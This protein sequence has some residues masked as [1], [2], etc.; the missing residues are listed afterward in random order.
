MTPDGTVSE[1]PKLILLV[2]DDPLSLKL[3][4]DVLQA[5]GY[6]TSE[7]SNGKEV[8]AVAGQRVPDLIVMDVGL[9]G[10]DGVEATKSLKGAA[11]TRNVPVLAVT[12]YAMPADEERM[13]NAGCEAFLTKPLHFSDFVAVVQGLLGISL[14][15]G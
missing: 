3:M 6:Q 1:R 10:M 4:R 9:P 13:R 7:I 15:A 8:L 12:A 2:E 11:S 14:P 5:H